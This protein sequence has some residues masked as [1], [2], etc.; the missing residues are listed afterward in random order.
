MSAHCLYGSKVLQLS[1]GD[2]LLFEAALHGVWA[3]VEARVS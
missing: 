1:Q 2:T 3:I